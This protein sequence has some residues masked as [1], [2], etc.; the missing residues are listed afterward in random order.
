MSNGRIQSHPKF[1][2]LIKEHDGKPT[3]PCLIVERNYTKPMP[4]CKKKL[5]NP[6]L[7]TIGTHSPKDDF[8]TFFA[9]QRLRPKLPKQ[10]NMLSLTSY[11]SRDS[12]T[13]FSFQ[14]DFFLVA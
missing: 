3:I 11:G 10:R 9:N 8:K 2:W 6:R 12:I 5:G 13:M 7:E 14:A 4:S 1:V